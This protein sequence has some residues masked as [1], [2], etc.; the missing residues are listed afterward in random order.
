VEAGE[1]ALGCL[2]VAGREAAPCL[3]LVDAAFDAVAVFVELG[4]VGEGPSA[5]ASLLLPVRGLVGLLRDDRLDVPFAQMSAVGA[6]G[7]SLVTGDRVGTGARAADRATD[8]DL[9]QDRDEPG[10]VGGLPLGQDEGER[11]AAGVGGEM[12]LAG[13]AAARAPEQ[14]GLQPGPTPLPNAPSFLP[15]R[16][17]LVPVA[18]TLRL[19][20]LP[21]APFDASAASS[22]DLRTS[23]PTCMPA[24]S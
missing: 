24:A 15:V 6:G 7:V 11:A 3:D 1:V 8:P 23:S 2:V 10:T 22:R 4:V 18:R 5:P 13:Q 21:A 17:G 20:F 19:S 9:V 14:G 12:N 16:D